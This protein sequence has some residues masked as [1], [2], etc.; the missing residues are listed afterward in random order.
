MIPLLP[1]HAPVDRINLRVGGWVCP[2]QAAVRAHE[3]QGP[4]NS[5]GGKGVE[6]RGC[7]GR[8]QQQ[9]ARDTMIEVLL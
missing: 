5:E 1:W 8:Y 9:I 7:S 6:V 3:L 2:S 4:V